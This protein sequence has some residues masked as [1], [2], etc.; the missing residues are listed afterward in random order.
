MSRRMEEKDKEGNTCFVKVL[1]RLFYQE[2]VN[3]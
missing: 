1:S 2:A 3:V